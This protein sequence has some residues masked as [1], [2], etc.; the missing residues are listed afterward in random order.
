MRKRVGVL[1]F[2]ASV[3]E[4]ELAVVHDL[5]VPRVMD[6]EGIFTGGRRVSDML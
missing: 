5:I 3:D 2:T 6:G 4:D 1:V